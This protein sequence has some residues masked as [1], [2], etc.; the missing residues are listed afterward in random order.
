MH[1]WTPRYYDIREDQPRLLT[2]IAEVLAA[3]QKDDGDLARVLTD[4]LMT[5]GWRRIPK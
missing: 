4:V 2:L 1:E 3:Y 5:D